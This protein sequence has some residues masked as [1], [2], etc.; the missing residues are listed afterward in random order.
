[1]VSAL[2]TGI[3][4]TATFTAATGPDDSV[5]GDRTRA[6]AGTVVSVSRLRPVGWN[7]H[8]EKSSACPWL[9]ANDVQPKDQTMRPA[10]EQSQVITEDGPLVHTCHHRPSDA[11]R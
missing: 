10:S 5:T 1:M 3:S 9:S 4:V 6:M 2:T 7:S 11:N 8:E